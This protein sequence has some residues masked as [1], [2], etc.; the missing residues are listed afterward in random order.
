[1]LYPNFKCSDVIESPKLAERDHNRNSGGLLRNGMQIVGAL[2]T[3]R[4]TPSGGHGP[5]ERS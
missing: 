4:T 3:F 2:F 1:M 5:C